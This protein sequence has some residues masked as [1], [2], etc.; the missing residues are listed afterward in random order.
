MRITREEYIEYLKRK[1]GKREKD[2]ILNPIKKL[3][4]DRNQA[5]LKQA[6]I[7]TNINAIEI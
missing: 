1:R 7:G 4:I 3:L 2:T 6:F 5:D